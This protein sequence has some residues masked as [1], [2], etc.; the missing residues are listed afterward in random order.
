MTAVAAAS[1]KQA[2]K[3]HNVVG[4]KAAD[5]NMWSKAF[6]S[7]EANSQLKGFFFFRQCHIVTPLKGFVKPFSQLVYYSSVARDE[8][9]AIY[10]RRYARPQNH[11]S[12]PKIIGSKKQRKRQLT[13]RGK[14]DII[15]KQFDETEPFQKN[16]KTNWLIFWNAIMRIAL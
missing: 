10:R 1:R 9:N 7:R 2:E 11:L 3:K 12:A 13:N 4:P 15:I 6:E 8:L 14:Y 16:L 5:R